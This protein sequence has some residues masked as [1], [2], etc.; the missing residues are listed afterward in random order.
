MSNKFR[1]FVSNYQSEL[2]INSRAK[3]VPHNEERKALCEHL[4]L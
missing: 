4:A 1:T 2:S 3:G